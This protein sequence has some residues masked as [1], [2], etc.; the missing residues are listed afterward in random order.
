MKR[1]L[2]LLQ[3]LFCLQIMYSHPVHLSVTNFDFISDSGKFIFSVRLFIDDFEHII[4]INY[5]TKF[6]VSNNENF[7]QNLRFVEHYFNENLRFYSNHHQLAYKFKSFE[8]RE[9]SV[10]FNFYSEEIN[11]FN[12]VNIRNTLMFDLY[13]D[14]K[15]LLII[16]AENFEKGYTFRVHKEEIEVDFNE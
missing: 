10:W 11:K 2:A 7:K 5:G 9:N 12:S 3:F 8:M 6:E 14:Q 16:K 13:P 1:L 4:S 15:N